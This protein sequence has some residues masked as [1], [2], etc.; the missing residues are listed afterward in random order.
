MRGTVGGLASPQPLIETM[1]S[2]YRT[3]Y[4]AELLC[5][6]FDEVLAP[7]FATLDCL[8]AYLDPRTVPEDMLDW[9]ASWIGL[10]VGGHDDPA[11]KR[12]RIITGAALLPWRGTARSVREAVVAAFNCRTEVIESGDATFSTEPNSEPG[13]RSRPILVV[14][15]ITS[16]DGDVDRRSLDELVDAVKPAHIPHRIEIITRG[17]SSTT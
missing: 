14:R 13:G 15:V 11:R 4:L 1:P 17:E 7:I 9:L 5:G 2:L 8:P 3:D 16:S 12:E 10:N 6:S